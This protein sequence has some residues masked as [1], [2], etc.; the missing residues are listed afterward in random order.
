MSETATFRTRT[1]KGFPRWSMTRYAAAR[2]NM[3]P[4]S[5]STPRASPKRVVNA[6]QSKPIS[7]TSQRNNVIPEP[8]RLSA[9][10][11]PR[12]QI[13]IARGTRLTQP[14]ARSFIGG[15]RTTAPVQAASSRMAVI[16]NPSQ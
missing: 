7:Q 12:D 4:A 13:S 6:A 11:H 3:A 9:H 14:H 16:R 15:F 1:T 10:P 8:S 5:H 2:P